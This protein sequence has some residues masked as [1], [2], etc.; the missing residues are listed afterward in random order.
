MK[1]DKQEQILRN[2]IVKEIEYLN[3]KPYYKGTQYLID[4]IYMMAMDTGKNMYNLS[5]EVYPVLA[6]KY[7]KTA[8]NIK[9][10]INRAN[11]CMYYECDVKILKKYFTLS[12]DSKPNTKT[13]IYAILNKVLK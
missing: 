5:K 1:I 10:N 8:H 9:C 4:T 12:M 6:K 11:T 7:N 13:I 2:K 3:Y